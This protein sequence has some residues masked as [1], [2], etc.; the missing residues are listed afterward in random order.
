MS[1]LLA[2]AT[3]TTLDQVQRTMARHNLADA[4]ITDAEFLASKEVYEALN[5]ST[6]T[7]LTII[8]KC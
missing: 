1:Q 2:Q 7:D 3:G 4:L 5:H 8:N 6:R